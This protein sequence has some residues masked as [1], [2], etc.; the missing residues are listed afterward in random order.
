[1]PQDIFEN[2]FFMCN[3]ALDEGKHLF[4]RRFSFFP[5]MTG[6]AVTRSR[7]VPQF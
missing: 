4:S 3:T 1:M 6:N 2:L 7:P 5:R